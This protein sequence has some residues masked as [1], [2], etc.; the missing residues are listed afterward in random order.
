MPLQ[1]PAEDGK[2]KVDSY[3]GPSTKIMAD[4]AFLQRLKDY[5]KDHIPEAVMKKIKTAHDLAEKLVNVTGDVLISSAIV[6]YLGVFSADYRDDALDLQV[7]Q[8][9]DAQAG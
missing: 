7:G 9:S 3:W 6:A 8:L 1:V 2:G 4:T 5:D